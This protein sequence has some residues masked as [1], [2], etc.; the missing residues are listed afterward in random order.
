MIDERQPIP[1]P[2][3][4]DILGEPSANL[5]LAPATRPWYRRPLPIISV[6]VVLLLLALIATPFVLRRLRGG[7]VRYET[8]TIAN[9]SMNVS[10]GASGNVTAPTYGASFTHQGTI[11]SVNVSIGQKVNSGDTLATLNYTLANGASATETLTAPHSGTVTAINGV[12][13]GRPGA[14]AV[15]LVDLTNMSLDLNVSES[16][17]ASVAKGQAVQFTVSAYPNLQ[18]FTGAVTSISPAGQNSGNVVT[19]PVTASIDTASLQGATL[20][21]GLSAT[22]TIITSQVANVPLVT[23][24][25]VTFAHNEASNGLISASDV[26]AATT[27]AQ[28]T[29]TSLEKSNSQLASQAPV[30][31]Y[32]LELAGRTLVVKPVVLGLTD[33]NNYVVLSG[34]SAG[35]SVVW[36]QTTAR[37]GGAGGGAGGGASGGASSGFIGAQLG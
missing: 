8:Q 22:G 30:A 28:A 36:N 6:I 18:P 4:A 21:D 14:V 24:T 33:G 37:L 3:A 5:P 26:T 7:V 12:V 19:F 29:L 25:A 13:D 32:V 16:D 2:R 17:I 15:E 23:A 34:L 9:G 1:Q 20:F 35:D 31:S 10:V 27:Q 11:A